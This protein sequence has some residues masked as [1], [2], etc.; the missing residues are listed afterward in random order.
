MKEEIY[1]EYDENGKILG[2]FG[3]KPNG[4]FV[5]ISKNTWEQ[6]LVYEKE[7]L[8]VQ[9]GEIKVSDYAKNKIDIARK[10]ADYKNFLATTDY[11]M[12]VDYFA[13]MSKDDQDSLISERTAARNFIRENQR[14]E[15]L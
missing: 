9:N 5:A 6:F 10:M 11:K 2:A 15:L 4:A 12:T 7:D 13:T 14:K 3:F 8:S 1:I